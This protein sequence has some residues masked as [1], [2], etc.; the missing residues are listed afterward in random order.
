MTDHFK[1]TDIEAVIKDFEQWHSRSIT[2]MFYPNTA[3][4]V[5]IA[6]PDNIVAFHKKLPE[7]KIVSIDLRDQAHKAIPALRDNIATL[8]A[9]GVSGKTP[10]Y[11]GFIQFQKNYND[12]LTLLHQIQSALT[13][14]SSITS[15]NTKDPGDRPHTAT[16]PDPLSAFA[17]VQ[18]P[19]SDDTPLKRYV[20][21]LKHARNGHKG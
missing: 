21:G 13:T 17:S 5:S 16:T 7:F 18:N 9:E 6:V 14:D 15:T 10:E 3:T 19:I 2:R 8:V 1:L 12:L 4:S 20:R 11:K